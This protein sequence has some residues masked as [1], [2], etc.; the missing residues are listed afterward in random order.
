MLLNFEAAV[1]ARRAEREFSPIPLP[2]DV[3]DAILEDARWA[4]SGFNLQPTR[5]VVVQ[6]ERRAALAAAAF[7]QRQIAEAPVTIVVVA[8]TRPDRTE[9]QRVLKT[10]RDAGAVD[11]AYVRLLRR[12]V[13][14]MFQRGPL[15]T[16]GIL[17]GLLTSTLGRWRPMPNFPAAAPRRWAQTQATIAAT[18][19]MLSAA[20]RGVASCPMEGFGAARVRRVIGLPREFHIALL[21]PLGYARATAPDDRPRRSR[22]PLAELVHWDTWTPRQSRSVRGGHA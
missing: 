21:V 16:L 15:G 8:D 1:R 6:G 17:K 3:I 4:P 20:A 9:F 22:L 18:H 7:G 5:F 10:D 19:L 11:D 14:L 12:T 13:A 2:R